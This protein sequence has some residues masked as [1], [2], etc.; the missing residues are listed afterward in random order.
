[1]ALFVALVRAAGLCV[2]KFSMQELAA[3]NFDFELGTFNSEPRAVLSLTLGEPLGGHITATLTN[4]AWMF[5]F[6]NGC[7]HNMCPL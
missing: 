6:F 4:T 3:K 1:M 7:L 5:F 2:E